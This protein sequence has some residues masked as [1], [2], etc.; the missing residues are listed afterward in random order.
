MPA[1]PE[2]IIG[3]DENSNPETA[4][5]SACGE[6]MP[7]G[8]LANVSPSDTIRWFV[9]NFNLHVEQ[10]HRYEEIDEADS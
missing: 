10:K 5:C 3:Y 1:T 6:E 4:V 8:D 2:L 9:T 7:Q